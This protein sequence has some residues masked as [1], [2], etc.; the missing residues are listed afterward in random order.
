LSNLKKYCRE[1]ED[2]VNIDHVRDAVVS[3]LQ[4]IA[5]CL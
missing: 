4:K 3:S 1:V 5:S 2:Q